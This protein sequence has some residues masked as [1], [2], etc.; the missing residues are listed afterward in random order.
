ARGLP[1]ADHGAAGRRRGGHPTDPTT[2]CRGTQDATQ[3]NPLPAKK[4][5]ALQI[6]PGGLRM[7]LQPHTCG[8]N[9]TGEPQRP[10]IRRRDV[11][12]MVTLPSPAMR[13]RRVHR[14]N[15]SDQH[16][17]NGAEA[18]ARAGHMAVEKKAW[19]GGRQRGRSAW[20]T[21]EAESAEVE[22][23]SEGMEIASV[24]VE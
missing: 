2:T 16:G 14:V 15:K 23:E 5:N 13:M 24:A 17:A 21:S 6:P 19:A 22:R 12:A 4:R 8:Q 1:L 3:R 9:D 20:W 10:R 18:H 11:A 7:P